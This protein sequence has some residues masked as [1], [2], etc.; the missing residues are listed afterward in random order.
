MKIEQIEQRFKEVTKLQP[1]VD[2]T[3]YPLTEHV[4]FEI[5][6]QEKKDNG[7][8]FTPLQLV[9][10]MLEISNPQP[11]KFN[12]DLCAGHGQ[13]TVRMLRRFVNQNKDFDIYCYLKNFHW[14]N[15]LNPKSVEDLIYIFGKDIN[16][17]AGPAQELKYMPEEDGVWK[18]GIWW[19]NKQWTK[20]KPKNKKETVLF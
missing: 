1:L 20:N 15:E 17:A 4:G 8:V 10:R 6:L 16:I 11:D 5:R 12:M 13:F 14:F 18:P 9:D 3:V 2:L 7:E 19:W